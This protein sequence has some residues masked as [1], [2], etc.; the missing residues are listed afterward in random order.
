MNKK[1]LDRHEQ[2]ATRQAYISIASMAAA[3]RA[4]RDLEAV[5]PDAELGAASA[6]VWS[7]VTVDWA[8]TEA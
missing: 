5:T 7:P 2:E 1:R 3:T 6:W 8:S 4:T